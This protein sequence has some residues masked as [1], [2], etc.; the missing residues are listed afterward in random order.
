MVRATFRMRS[1]ARAESRELFHG[2]LEQ[3]AERGVDGAV[4]PDLGVRHPGVGGDARAA[5][6]GEFALTGGVDA[7]PDGR[8]SFAGLGGA[9]FREG[10]GGRL[11]VQVDPVQQR[12]A[13]AG[14]VALDLGG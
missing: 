13:D 1:Y 9:Q 3:V 7:L 10:K 2:V 4:S 14:A 6:P 12:A 5:Q 11:D 8:G